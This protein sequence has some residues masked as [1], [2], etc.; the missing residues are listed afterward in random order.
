MYR[1]SD[2]INVTGLLQSAKK[3][4]V[5]RMK[6]QHCEIIQKDI[7]EQRSKVP[8]TSCHL[9]YYTLWGKKTAPL[10]FCN[11]FVKQYYS[12]IIIGTCIVE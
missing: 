1:R 5:I 2:G 10:Y 6:I 3:S 9:M 4:D 11:N 8:V 7:H 12:E